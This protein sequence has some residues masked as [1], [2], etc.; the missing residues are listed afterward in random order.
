MTRIEIIAIGL[1]KIYSV[2][3]LHITQKGN[4][5]PAYK[6][7]DDGGFHTSRHRDG[8]LWMSGKDKVQ[9]RKLK[10]ISDFSGLEFIETQGFGL[11]S[12]PQ[13][14]EEYKLKKSDGIFAI[15]MRNYEDGRFN[16][17]IAIF[18]DEG[19]PKLLITSG[20]SLPT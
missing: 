12:L 11:N 14:Y 17:N 5:Y 8:S 6:I 15:D 1:N 2:G 9:I 10:N 7:K 18:T 3:R 4:V 16:L 20:L 19:L 13:I